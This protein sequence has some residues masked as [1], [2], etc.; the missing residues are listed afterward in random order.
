MRESEGKVVGAGK[1]GGE[2]VAEGAGWWVGCGAVQWSG[3]G[4]GCVR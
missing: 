4:G 3:A 1:G 2:M